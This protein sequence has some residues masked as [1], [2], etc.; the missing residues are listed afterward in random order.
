MGQGYRSWEERR[1]IIRAVIAETNPPPL[2][3]FRLT[4]SEAVFFRARAARAVATLAQKTSSFKAY[5]ALPVAK[6]F[7]Y[8]IYV[9]SAMI[10]AALCAAVYLYRHSS[11]TSDT[12]PIFTAFIAVVVAAV[13]WAV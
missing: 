7:K 11:P 3:S 8:V 2:E 1:D 12:T 9:S 5:Y 6:P 4:P 10:V 13:G